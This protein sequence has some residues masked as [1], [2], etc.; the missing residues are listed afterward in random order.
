M[1]SS[2]RGNLVLNEEL[3]AR[4]TINR[5]DAL[6]LLQQLCADCVPYDG[7]EAVLL[8][9]SRIA[10]RTW[11]PGRLQLEINRLDQD[12]SSVTLSGEHAGAAETS[13]VSNIRS[14]FSKLRLIAEDPTVLLPFEVIE[15]TP[16]RVTLEAPEVKRTTTI[17]PAAFLDA[18]AAIESH[19]ALY[20]ES[21]RPCPFDSFS[22][23]AV[24]LIRE[25]TPPLQTVMGTQ[26]EE[27]DVPELDTSDI[28]EIFEQGWELPSP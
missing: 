6:Q 4:A 7:E 14:S 13:F 19:D 10:M 26:W 28:D 23:E 17:P 27:E 16:D 11:L 20:F 15:V 9:I 1:T 21:V 18:N 2:L 24:T 3:F 8:M 22:D 5:Q 25:P 12:R